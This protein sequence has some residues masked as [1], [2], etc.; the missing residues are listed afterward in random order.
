MIGVVSGKNAK[1]SGM[2]AH[3]RTRAKLKQAIVS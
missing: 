3:A 1:K 2:R